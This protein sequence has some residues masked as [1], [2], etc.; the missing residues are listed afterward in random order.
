MEAETIDILREGIAVR[1]QR[2]ALR[3]EQ[4]KALEERLAALDYQCQ[5]LGR[6]MMIDTSTR[7]MIEER[8]ARAERQLEELRKLH[9]N[10]GGRAKPVRTW[11][12]WLT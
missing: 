9:A 2:I 10:A 12:K 5:S 6:A 11:L 4:I 3:D 1:D 8:A 7:R